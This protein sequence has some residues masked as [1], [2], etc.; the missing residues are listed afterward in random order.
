[1]ELSLF[2]ESMIPK[3]RITLN[4]FTW[5]MEKK[6]WE[7]WFELICMA[8]PCRTG[9]SVIKKYAKKTEWGDIVPVFQFVDLCQFLCLLSIC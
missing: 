5:K 6:L 8:K 2:L 4:Y 9:Q 1:M 7:I 3:S